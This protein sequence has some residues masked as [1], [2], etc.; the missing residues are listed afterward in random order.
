M[1]EAAQDFSG[2]KLALEAVRVTEAAAR[3][4]SKWMGRGDEKAVDRAS[5]EAMHQALL[6]LNIDGT[7]RIGESSGNGDSKLLV[8]EKVGSGHDAIVDVALMPVEGATIVAKG[9]PNGISVIAMAEGGGF[10]NVPEI[11]MDKIAVGGNLPDNVIDLDKEPEENLKSVAEAKGVDVGDLVVCIL[12]RPRHNRLIGKIREAGGRIMLIADGDVSG[13]IATSWAESGIDLYMGAGG[14]PQGV[15]AAA[16]LSCFGGQMQGRL[17][18]RDNSDRAAAHD[19]GIT[20]PDRKFSIG[21][22][23]SGDITFAATGI[24]S[25]ALLGGVTNLDGVEVSHSMVMRSRTGTLRFVE[26]YHQ[27]GRANP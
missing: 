24:T 20:E 12:D 26:G 6:E 15:L 5:V 8:G 16:A 19:A 9:E 14:A 1:N 10:L 4:A 13:I 22:M 23:A 27:F 25:G 3:A 2:R 21:D 7:I 18:I 17:I 11:Y